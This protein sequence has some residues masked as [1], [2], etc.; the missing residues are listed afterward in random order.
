MIIDIDSFKGINDSNGHLMGDKVIINIARFLEKYFGAYG[1]VS[2]FGGDEFAV[3]VTRSLSKSDIERKIQ[4]FQYDA[5][6]I[7]LED[8]RK[9][10]CSIGICH[11]DSEKKFDEVY[12]KAD[13][14]LY[15]IKTHG[16]NGYK[17]YQKV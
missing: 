12:R 8:N 15:Y 9:V 14:M 2:R 17:F 1:L 7:L 5:A 13:E 10:T 11:V 6:S 4:Q 16:R 3:F